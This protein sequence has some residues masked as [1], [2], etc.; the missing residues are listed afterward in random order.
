MKK[1]VFIVG[2]LS[3]LFFSACKKELSNDFIRYT[4]HPLNDTAWIRSIPSS[5]TVNEVLGV[6]LPKIIV[7]SFDV[8]KDTTLTYGDSLSVSFTAGSCV[9]APGNG[10]S[11][12]TTASG[13]VYLEIIRLTKK[14]DY[15]KAFKATTS[16]GYL[17]ESAGGFFVR[18]IKDGKELTL[19]PG[20]SFTIRFSDTEDPKTNMQAFYGKETSPVPPVNIIDTGFTWVRGADTS[21]LPTFQKQGTGN[22]VIK[23]YELKATSFRWIAAERYTDSTKAKTKITAILA[24]NYTN[25]TTAVFAVFANQKT[26][27]YLAPDYASRSYA[28]NY[29]PIGSKITLLSFSKI[30][31]DLYMGIKEINDVGRVTSYTITPG[32]TT[33][34]KILTYLNTL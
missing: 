32:K 7:D 27:V 4:N 21:W 25:K 34:L 13:K 20:A 3:L 8:S 30:G 28:A 29:I 31:G 6:L 12:G 14:G 1:N 11:P 18:V 16:N 23:G 33:L 15:I 26:I 22:T 10:G 17:L 19:A 9:G 24:P 5:A 2:C